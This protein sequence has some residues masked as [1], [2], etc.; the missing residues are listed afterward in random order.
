MSPASSNDKL[1]NNQNKPVLITMISGIFSGTIS[2][3]I[4][5]PVDTIKAKVQV[6]NNKTNILSTL[7]STIKNEG[8]KGLYKGLPV[9]TL[10]SIPGCMIYF[11]SYEYSKNYLLSNYTFLRNS[12]FLT[13]FIS[14]IFAEIISCVIFVPVD[15]I[16]E[17]RQ[18][19]YNTKLSYKND[20]DAFKTIVK[21]EGLRGIYKAYGATVL[22]F[23]PMSAFYF[24]FYE[25]FKGFFV[26]NDAI[27][28]LT[29]TNRNITFTHSLICSS[30]ASGLAAYITTPLDLVKLRMQV[31]RSLKTDNIHTNNITEKHKYRSLVQGLKSIYTY[32]G[33]TGLFKGSIP[34]VLYHAPTGAISM[35][36]LEIMKPKVKNLLN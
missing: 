12:E 3:I 31:Q 15:V 9:S 30:L 26:N 6:I 24:M 29:N 10:G 19:Q 5:H 14:G 2:K 23:G 17:R 28:Y 22:S 33:I 36:L 13:Y 8:F 11:G 16:K 21:Q 32:E 7:K 35:T 25:Y 1:L 4:T 18:V 34:R 27:T 20:L